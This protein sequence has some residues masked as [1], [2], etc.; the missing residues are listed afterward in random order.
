VAAGK[1]NALTLEPVANAASG[2]TSG[3]TSMYRAEAAWLKE[4][5]AFTATV[6]EVEIRG[7]KFSNVTFVYPKDNSHEGHQH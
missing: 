2:E 7:A 1:T 4:V 3:D 6:S 5:T